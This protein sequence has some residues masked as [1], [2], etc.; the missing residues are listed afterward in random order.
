MTTG[1]P[2]RRLLHPL[3]DR[4]EGETD[5]KAFASLHRLISMP[6][7]EEPRQWR[8]DFKVLRPPDLLSMPNSN[9]LHLPRLLLPQQ[10]H[11]LGSIPGC[12]VS[13]TMKKPPE[14]PLLRARSASFSLAPRLQLLK[15]DFTAESSNP[16][17]SWR[18][19]MLLRLPTSAFAS[20]IPPELSFL[21]KLSLDRKQSS[22]H[23]PKEVS[24]QVGGSTE[25]AHQNA[26]MGDGDH[27]KGK[28]T[29]DVGKESSVDKSTLCSLGGTKDEEKERVK[30]GEQRPSPFDSK[31]P[32]QEMPVLQTKT[33]DHTTENTVP[34]IQA[35]EV[36]LDVLLQNLLQTSKSTATGVTCIAPEF[37]QPSTV[38]SLP[39]QSSG[40]PHSTNPRPLSPR[41]LQALAIHPEKAVPPAAEAVSASVPSSPEAQLGGLQAG[42]DRSQQPRP[43]EDPQELDS[44][45]AAIDRVAHKIELEYERN[46]EL[47]Q[48]FLCLHSPTPNNMLPFESETSGRTEN[49]LKPAEVHSVTPEEEFHYGGL[50]TSPSP[51][52]TEGVILQ[53]EAK[54]EEGTP[55]P[56]GCLR[57]LRSVLEARTQSRLSSAPTSARFSSRVSATSPS[58]ARQSAR[59]A[60]YVRDLTHQGPLRRELQHRLAERRRKEAK[61]YATKI[62]AELEQRSANRTP[63]INP[64]PTSNFGSRRLKATSKIVHSSRQQGFNRA[65]SSFRSLATPNRRGIYSPSLGGPIAKQSKSNADNLRSPRRIRLEQELDDPQSLIS[66]SSGDEITRK[67]LRGSPPSGKT[68]PIRVSA[69]NDSQIKGLPDSATPNS[70]VFIDW[71]KIDELIESG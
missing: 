22:P 15:Y 20:S 64:R 70:S 27:S 33:V 38:R 18:A 43:L 35:E 51:L 71:D 37:F 23:L 48:T 7:E 53:E 39:S 56:A 24:V 2:M 11:R 61:D 63:S 12:H 31:D 4:L 62:L 57:L 67:I 55:V 54:E 8:S 45:L 60:T 13:D 40:F 68:T 34:L 58:T 46:K 16:S 50:S 29:C 32:P 1:S 69:I 65:P 19:P 66:D 41:P 36:P 25:P 17:A 6:R 42:D 30:E 3:I 44:R 52:P 5:E 59:K 10:I 26:Q 9:T 28:E 21:S 47:L 14:I 49:A